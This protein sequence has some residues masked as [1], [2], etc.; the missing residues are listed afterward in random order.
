MVSGHTHQ[1]LDT[2]VDGV[3]HIWMPS[4]AFILPGELQTRIG[5]KLVGMGMIDLSNE[6]AQF[7]L[8]CPDGMVRHDVTQLKF[9]EAV[10]REV[11]TEG[12]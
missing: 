8:W 3:R 2:V 10:A 12:A 7:H 11:A 4:T 9:L 1:Y 6:D 5:E